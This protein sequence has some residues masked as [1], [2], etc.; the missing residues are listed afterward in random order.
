MIRCL[1]LAEGWHPCESDAVVD[2][3]KQ[4]PIGIALHSVTG[5][6]CGTWVHPLSRWCLGPAVDPAADA[7]IQ[8]EM[9]TSCFDAASLVNW[10]RGNSVAAGKR[11]TECLARFAVRVSRG[12]GSC[13][14]VKLKCISPIPISTTPDATIVQMIRDRIRFS[15]AAVLQAAVCRAL[16][17]N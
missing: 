16:F 6:I 13:S 4:L 15:S 8:A 14:A 10:Q 5:E 12:L 9:C 3:P 2:D 1:N 7:A 17:C 11:M